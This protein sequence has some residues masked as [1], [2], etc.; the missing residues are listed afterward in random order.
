[1][2]PW[3]EWPTL[4]P[5]IKQN[6]RRHVP[7]KNMARHFCSLALTLILV[8]A[9][10]TPSAHAQ[11][12]AKVGSNGSAA[13]PVFS[14]TGPDAADLGAAKGFPVGTR[15]MASQV[16]KLVGTYIHFH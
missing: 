14:G 8:V 11:D 2:S 3:I 13:V 12:A 7:E 15:A 4:I 16:A 5:S 6:S 10:W 1:M 9:R